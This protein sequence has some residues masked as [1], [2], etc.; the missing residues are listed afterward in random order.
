MRI[1]IATVQAPFIR[2]GAEAHAEGL[3]TVLVAAGH[4][5]EIVA[6][7]VRWHPPETLVDQMLACRLLDLSALNGYPAD[8]VIGLRFPAYLVRHPN[9]VLWV[10]HQ[11]RAAYDLW[12]RGLGELIGSPDGPEVRA[13][14]HAADRRLIP[15]ARAVFANS[16]TVAERLHRYSGIDA[17]PLYHPPPHAGDFY[18]AAEAL[19]PY[20]LF[21][22][23]LTSTKRQALVLQALAR[24]R[25]D[26]RVWFA[27]QPDDP[28]H[29]AELLALA[30][31]LGVERRAV[32]LGAVTELEK[33]RLYAGARGVVFPPLDEDYGYVTLEAM[34][35][36]K[37][38]VTCTDSGGPL[39]FV[40]DG[41]TGRVVEPTPDALAA[42]LDDVWADPDRA[43]QWGAAGRAR[44][45]ALEIGW[46][47]V[48]RRLT[49]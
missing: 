44:Y 42:A 49:A 12:D 35:A 25:A 30:N 32:W 34:L 48:V 33:R 18:H 39:E 5:A 46:D 7:P 40:T 26:V 47:S 41:R 24:T 1:L 27:G 9:K 16:R 3:R 29:A 15:E 11:Y 37:P 22:S 31:E 38:V 28:N 14:V 13:A 19:E 21:P 8:R 6:I 23:R 10:L 45:D 17:P 2:G 20:L 43:T 4:E 36:G